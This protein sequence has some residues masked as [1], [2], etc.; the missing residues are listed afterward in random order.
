MLLVARRPMPQA[1]STIAYGWTLL[2]TNTA[3]L[4]VSAVTQL[5]RPGSS[6]LHIVVQHRSPRRGTWPRGNGDHAALGRARTASAL[7]AAATSGGRPGGVPCRV[8]AA[9]GAAGAAT[10]AWAAAAPRSRSLAP[11]RRAHRCSC[12][13]PGWAFG[14][15]GGG[16]GDVGKRTGLQTAGYAARGA[17]W[18]V[19]RR[20]GLREAWPRG[21][22]LW[23]KVRV[24]SVRQGRALA[25]W[26]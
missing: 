26:C 22:G 23:G 8:A 3:V 15:M 11:A 20:P 21:A 14:N 25:R 9:A 1:P 13:P 17:D 4:T 5:E 18:R 16:Q 12:R 24:S 10:A 2:E 6:S 7:G 19:L